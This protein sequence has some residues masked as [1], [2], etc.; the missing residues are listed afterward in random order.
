MAR[1]ARKSYEEQLQAV[2]EQME[3][4][5]QRLNKLK[6][7]REMIFEKKKKSEMKELYQL[8]KEQ[9][10]SIEDAVKLLSQKESA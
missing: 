1:G 4:C 8:L 5:N 9:N 7:E 10:V 2:E 6:E 3:R